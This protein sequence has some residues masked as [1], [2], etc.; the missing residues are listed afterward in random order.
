LKISYY[1]AKKNK[2]IIVQKFYLTSI[3]IRSLFSGSDY[4]L[5]QDFP[6]YLLILS[7]HSVNFWS[8]LGTEKIEGNT[9]LK[10]AG[11]SRSFLLA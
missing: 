7:L 2:L 5:I 9:I 1:Q 8:I 6:D 11:F 3:P 10:L 4:P